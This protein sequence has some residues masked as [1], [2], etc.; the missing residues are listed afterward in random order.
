MLV[1][2]LGPT[3]ACELT[4]YWQKQICGL[5]SLTVP[6]QLKTIRLRS[7]NICLGQL[8]ICMRR[9]L[10]MLICTEGLQHVYTSGALLPLFKERPPADIKAQPLLPLPQPLTL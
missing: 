4:G 8:Q 9:L 2:G 10:M 5:Q 6:V 1:G 3:Q 7:N